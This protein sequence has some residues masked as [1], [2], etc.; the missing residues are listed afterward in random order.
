MIVSLVLTIANTICCPAC[1][2]H[3]TSVQLTALT[4]HSERLACSEQQQ[5]E[6]LDHCSVAARCHI[7]R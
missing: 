1:M 2:A 4:E 3:I 7:G 5:N 6:D